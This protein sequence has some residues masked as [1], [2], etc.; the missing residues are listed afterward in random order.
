MASA[1]GAFERPP[2]RTIMVTNTHNI[3]IVPDEPI[4]CPKDQHRFP[5]HQGIT[6]QTME[7]Y[8]RAFESEFEKRTQ[9]LRSEIELQVR[10]N[11]Q[12][13]FSAKQRELEEQLSERDEAVKQAQNLLKKA[14]NEARAKALAEFEHEKRG[15]LDDL[16]EK[17][18]QL[19]QSRERE[20][21]LLREKKKLEQVKENLELE[22]ARKLDRERQQIQ[23]E[24]AAKEA[25]KTRLRVAEM[26]K[27]LSDALRLNE[28]LT[29]KLEQGSQQLQGEVLELDLED[30]LRTDFPY[31]KIERVSKGV[32]GADILQRVHSPNGQLCGTIVW[33]AK[34]AKS[35]SDKWLQKLKDNQ[36][37]AGAEF[38]VIVTSALPRDSKEPFMMN[39]D[40]WVVTDPVIRPIAETLRAMLIQSNKLKLA[41]TGKNEKMELVYN[42]LCSPQFAQRIRAVVETFVL[43]KR[44]LDQERNALAKI[45]KQREAQIERVASNVMEMCGEL[46]A[47]SQS[48]L[49]KLEEIKELALPE[50]PVGTSEL[51]TP[52]ALV[53]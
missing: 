21:G 46:Q 28:D 36:M 11:A 12:K 22:N 53:N 30:R 31:D 25:A 10:K 52:K 47:I 39:G 3:I 50:E 51:A 33:E 16:T 13:E 26:E 24:A 49:H 4:V 42:Y 7:K 15:I 48:S 17:E 20:L 14:Q 32:N 2:L 18:H 45:W 43:M 37:Q 23:E 27:K 41:S 35:W 29:R 6:Q 38:A 19:T 5:L 44:S 1:V 40:I 34:R 9:E 8:E